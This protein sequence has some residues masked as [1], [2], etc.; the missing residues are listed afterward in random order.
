M[1]TSTGIRGNEDILATFAID[2]AP[3]VDFHG[4]IKKMEIESSD[5]DDNDL[6]FQEAAGGDTKDYTVKVT[7]ITS[8]DPTSFWRWCWDNAGSE[9]EV[10]YGPRGNAV[11]SADKPHFLMTCK[12]PGKPAISQEAKRTKDRG[13]FEMELEV[14]T[15]PTLDEGA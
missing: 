2:P 7:A 6:T 15:G 3:A 10:V 5:K 12:V 8:L 11:A 9:V 4:D 1:T 14:L 13:E